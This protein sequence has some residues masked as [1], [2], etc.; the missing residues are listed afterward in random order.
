MG[1]LD[2]LLVVALEQAVAA[3]LC[4]ARLAAAGARVI[5]VERADGD[6]ARRYDHVVNGESAYFLWLNRGKQSIALDIKQKDDAALLHRIINKADVFIQNLAPGATSRAGFDSQT[7]RS[8]N[9]RLI[10]CDISGYGSSGPYVH[11]KAYDLLIQ[12][13]AGLAAITGGPD[14]PARVGVSVADICCGMNA[15]AAILEALIERG[16]TDHGKTVEVSL[17]GSLADWMTVP[18]LHFVHTGAAPKRIGLHHASIA[19]YGLYPT[20]D[21][22]GLVLAIQNDREWRRFCESILSDCNIAT[23]TR[24]SSNIDRVANRSSLDEIVSTATQRFEAADLRKLLSAADIAAAAVN[25]V[26]DFSVHPQLRTNFALVNGT[27][28][29]LPAHPWLANQ[30]IPLDIPDID[31]H[32]AAIRVEFV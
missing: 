30:D 27:E 24:Y 11:E 16:H 7:L 21:G 26:A 9:S 6:F 22:R 29:E 10:T 14:G 28:V 1:A 12:C 17:F 15:H 23:D 8:I 20:A 2:G 13:E 32:G 18:Y 5:K 25:D 19:P 4:T 3:P 31:Q